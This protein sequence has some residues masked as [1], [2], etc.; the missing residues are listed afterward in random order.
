MLKES[1]PILSPTVFHQQLELLRSLTTIAVVGMSPNPKRASHDVGLYLRSRGY[2]VIP[3][4]PA[5]AEIAGLKVFPSLTAAVHAGEQIDLVD[6]FVSG[7]TVDAVVAE[8][9]NLGLRRI[10][11]QPGTEF[12]AALTRAREAGIQVIERACTMAVLQRA[13]ATEL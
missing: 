8:A 4:H 12:A 5:A 6:L 2:R 11:F 7:P 9:I 1:C 10:W 3:I 13:G